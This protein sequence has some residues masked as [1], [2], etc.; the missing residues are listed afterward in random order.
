LQPSSFCAAS[1]EATTVASM[2]GGRR[3]DRR[4]QLP[5]DENTMQMAEPRPVEGRSLRHAGNEAAARPRP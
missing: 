4:Q 1:S 2:E 5:A 3:S